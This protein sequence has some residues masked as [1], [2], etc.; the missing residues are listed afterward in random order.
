MPRPHSQ[1]REKRSQIRPQL[2]RLEKE[3]ML[4]Q[5][6][7]RRLELARW[8]TTEPTHPQREQLETRYAENLVEINRL[9]RDAQ[10]QKRSEFDKRLDFF[11]S[12]TLPVAAFTVVFMLVLIM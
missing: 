12:V 5:K 7:I 4:V 6:Q 10:F 2:K 9:Y 8:V 3:N 1:L 11:V